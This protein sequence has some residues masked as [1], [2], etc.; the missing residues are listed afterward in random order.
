MKGTI[1]ACLVELFAIDFEVEIT[2]MKI[3]LN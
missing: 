3:F 2:D 1:Y